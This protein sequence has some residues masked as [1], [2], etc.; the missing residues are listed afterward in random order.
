M[1]LRK[2]ESQFVFR[3]MNGGTCIDGIDSFT[4][5]CPPRLTGVLCECL[6][7]S[8]YTLDCTYNE[9]NATWLPIFPTEEE[10]T[11]TTETFTTAPAFVSSPE[12][13]I[14]L[15]QSTEFTKLTEMTETSQELTDTTVIISKTH[16]T[17]SIL[18]ST[19]K[20]SLE[21]RSTTAT[22]VEE[23]FTT[24]TPISG[25]PRSFSSTTTISP[26]HTTTYVEES[27]TQTTS[28]TLST[29]VSTS[30]LVPE[31]PTKIVPPT[32][33]GKEVQRTTSYSNISILTSTPLTTSSSVKPT[34]LTIIPTTMT[35]TTVSEETPVYSTVFKQTS[36]IT[37]TSFVPTVSDTV[38]VGVLSTLMSQTE[39]EATTIA[40]GTAMKE[41]TTVS[42]EPRTEKEECGPDSP[43]KSERPCIVAPGEL[44]V[45]L[46]LIY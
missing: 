32:I 14:T 24:I 5:S 45:S 6:I 10:I 19:E 16:F 31:P 43:C 27:V 39:S 18:I 8:N 22:F 35:P 26:I 37:L 1:L 2:L 42:V 36:M 20:S 46:F 34:I 9:L 30:T 29:P 44:E 15:V 40:Y 4:C 41:T 3:C 28:R 7:L 38:P 23:N 21:T 13:P 11:T 17:P 12:V 33:T 25:E